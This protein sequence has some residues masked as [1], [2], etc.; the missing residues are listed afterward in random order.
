MADDYDDNILSISQLLLLLVSK[1]LSPL[2]QPPTFHQRAPLLL[3]TASLAAATGY[4]FRC[5]PD[6][7]GQFMDSQIEPDSQVG[8]VYSV[9]KT[10]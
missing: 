3:A 8:E 4:I 7:T 6:D 9:K 1:P 10:Y 2:S 5:H